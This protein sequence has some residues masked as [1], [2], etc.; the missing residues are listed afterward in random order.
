MSTHVIITFCI[1]TVL[2]IVQI[3]NDFERYT[4]NSYSIVEIT[5]SIV[6]L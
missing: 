2:I 5:G 4:F 6:A 1:V 3:S